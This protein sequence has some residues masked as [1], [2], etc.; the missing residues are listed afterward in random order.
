MVIEDV[1][2]ELV[3]REWALE[4]ASKH[5]LFAP[6]HKGLTPSELYPNVYDTLSMV[7]QSA[8]FIAG[9]KVVS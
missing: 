3:F 7:K 9:N 2:T 6:P 8:S 4:E 1:A 5:P